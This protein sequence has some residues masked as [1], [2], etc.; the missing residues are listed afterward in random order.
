MKV[1]ESYRKIPLIFGILLLAGLL[2]SRALLSFTELFILVYGLCIAEKKLIS[3]FKKEI[4]WSISPLILF[5]LGFYQSHSFEW[6]NFDYLLTLS[7][8]TSIF[9]FINTID[10]KQKKQIIY[11]WLTAIAISLI[12][13][14]GWYVLHIKEAN[15]KYG[16]GQSLPTFMDM[17]HVRYGLFL[18]SGVLIL[19]H[20]KLFSKKNQ[21]IF[22]VLLSSII[23]FMSVRTAWVALLIILIIHAFQRIKWYYFLAGLFFSIIIGFVAYTF[24]PTIQQKINYTIYDWQMYQS[25]NYTADFSDGARRNI[26]QVTWKLISEQHQSNAGWTNVST[27][28]QKGLHQQYPNTKIEYGLPFNQYLFWWLGGGWWTLILF[29]GWLLYPIIIDWNKNNR[30][31]MSWTIV[32]AIS[33]LV[34]SNLCFQ[35][36]VLLHA[37]AIAL[38]WNNKKII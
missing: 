24:I 11:C 34:E 13:P 26:N 37:F 20:Y 1:T 28:L 25:K 16:M 18:C 38:L 32:I 6:K 22:I 29:F 7:V 12:Y 9:I 17:D 33:C 10:E 36:G 30:A 5:F 23:V 27:V 2:W 35:Y 14:L 21:A 4:I 3:F 31:L 19:L 15:T 8:Y